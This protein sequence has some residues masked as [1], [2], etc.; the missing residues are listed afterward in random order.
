[1]MSQGGC[2]KA[3]VWLLLDLPPARADG[4]CRTPA[5]FSAHLFSA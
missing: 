5:S 4:A 2:M 1:M 3:P